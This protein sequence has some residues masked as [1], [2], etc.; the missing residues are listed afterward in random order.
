MR[1]FLG[2]ADKLTCFQ[3]PSSEK[4]WSKYKPRVPEISVGCELWPGVV[5]DRRIGVRA[6]LSILSWCTLSIPESTLI[7]IKNQKQN[8][9]NRKVLLKTTTQSV[10][11][12]PIRDCA[13]GCNIREHTRTQLSAIDV[14]KK[15][16][17]ERLHLVL[18]LRKI[19]PWVNC[20]YAPTTLTIH[21]TTIFRFL[22]NFFP[23]IP[24]ICFVQHDSPSNQSR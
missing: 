16:S 10:Q 2:T 17:F 5:G 20:P 23:L 3:G 6:P 4:F 15:T 18:G 21:P 13:R 12:P 24:I 9:F 7:T 8:S 1:C 22:C 14:T 19:A 11:G